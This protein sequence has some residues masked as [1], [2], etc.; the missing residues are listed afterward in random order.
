MD[1][2][3]I[4]KYKLAGKIAID[5][6]EH[7]SKLIKSGVKLLDVANEVESKIKK[8]GAGIAFPVNISVN[9]VAAHY[10]P[11]LNDQRVFH[12]GDVVKV[13]VGAHVE[14]YIGDTAKT[15]EVGTNR[16]QGII[17]SSERALQAGL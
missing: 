17:Q 12:R 5:A 13:D 3:T 6:R 2:E 14:G 16:Y 7:G 4:K 10:T 11:S 8:S 1:E 9:D 15:I